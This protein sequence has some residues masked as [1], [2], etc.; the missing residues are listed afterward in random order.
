MS[1]IYR[2]QQTPINFPLKNFEPFVAPQILFRGLRY[3]QKR[4]I[5]NITKTSNGQYTS[6]ITGNE[7]SPY[8]C[9][10]TIHKKHITAFSCSCPYKISICKHI[11]A[12]LYHIKDIALGGNTVPTPPL[13][14]TKPEIQTQT[15]HLLNSL[16]LDLIKQFLS[17]QC[18]HIPLLQ[19]LLLL[20]F[21]GLNTPA[22][23]EYYAR[24]F[25]AFLDS[26][27]DLNGKISFLEIE[28]LNQLVEIIL[29]W[30]AQ[31]T[32]KQEILV[33]LYSASTIIKELSHTEHSFDTNNL[34][35]IQSFKMALAYLDTRSQKQLPKSVR[36]TFFRYCLSL[37]D[38]SNKS[39]KPWTGE[40]LRI[41]INLAK[42][43]KEETEIIQRI[44]D[45]SPTD[46]NYSQALL[47]ALRIL[48]KQPKNRLMIE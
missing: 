39:P 15:H 8:A 33:S 20:K 26:I 42:S 13:S 14:F 4:H 30:G 47:L 24:L 22:P 16:P 32:N 19:Y 5:T 41:A 40:I 18:K 21:S 38:N 25:R 9:S 36:K 35:H 28:K 10:I 23:P 11:A 31:A 17:E 12:L 1:E 43:N 2:I 48:I 27:A 46:S 6:L 3:F 29:T 44:A 34:L 45:I 7:A 37:Y